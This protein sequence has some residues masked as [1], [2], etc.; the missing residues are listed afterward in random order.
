MTIKA[1]RSCRYLVF[2]CTGFRTERSGARTQIRKDG[3]GCGTGS[4]RN[5]RPYR[6]SRSSEG[7]PSSMHPCL[8]QRAWDERQGTSTA[9]SPPCGI[10]LRRWKVLFGNTVNPPTELLSRFRWSA[11]R[12]AGPISC[13]E[14]IG[15]RPSPSA[16]VEETSGPLSVGMSPISASMWQ[17]P[18]NSTENTPFTGSSIHKSFNMP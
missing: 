11:A 10:T 18:M 2:G 6:E 9:S 1:A 16:R 14:N 12:L 4:P 7:D 5:N 8:C 13:W 3:S 17:G 15:V